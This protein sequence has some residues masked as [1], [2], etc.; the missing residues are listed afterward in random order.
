MASGRQRLLAELTGATAPG[1]GTRCWVEQGV[2]RAVAGGYMQDPI[3]T[4]RWRGTDIE[5]SR[6]A[7]YDPTDGD[8]VLLLIQP[9]SVVILGRVL[10]PT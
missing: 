2:I 1:N 3:V 9:P 4:V 8:V 6:M 10:G 5:A 7:D